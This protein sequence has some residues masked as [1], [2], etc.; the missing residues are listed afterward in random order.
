MSESG[1]AGWCEPGGGRDGVLLRGWKGERGCVRGNNRG[2][3][4]IMLV[5]IESDVLRVELFGYP[6]NGFRGK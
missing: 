1:G 5:R 2:S 4:V 6:G 3:R